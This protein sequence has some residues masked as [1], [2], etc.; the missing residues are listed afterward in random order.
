MVRCSPLK[1]A[2]GKMKGIRELMK[3]K[4]YVEAF[5]SH[6]HYDQMANKALTIFVAVIAGTVALQLKF[7]TTEFEKE[8]YLY[9]ALSV[10][11]LIVVLGCLRAYRSFDSYATIALNVASAIETNDKRFK[12]EVVGF[13]YVFKHIDNFKWLSST[14]TSKTF[15]WL[16]T[17]GTISILFNFVLGACLYIG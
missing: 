12:G 7:L 2:L 16:A 11:N 9:L 1:R 8:A 10:T 5:N 14:G 17:L 6:R 3:D 15:K 13:A 4:I